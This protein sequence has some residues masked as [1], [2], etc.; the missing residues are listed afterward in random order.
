MLPRVITLLLVV[1]MNSALL[2]QQPV[3]QLAPQKILRLLGADGKTARD[4]S[5]VGA[6][7]FLDQN[8]DNY[9]SWQEY[10]VNGRYGT[11][12][13]RG[14]IFRVTDKDLNGFVTLEEYRKNRHVTDEAKELLGLADANKDGYLSRAEF[15]EHPRIKNEKTAGQVFDMLDLNKDG[16][17][18]AAE[19]LYTWQT[20]MKSLPAAPGGETAADSKRDRKASKQRRENGNP[21]LEVNRQ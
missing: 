18:Y 1:L 17:T 4:A 8:R 3:H 10:V 13:I 6:F 20:W 12:I 15:L 7:R 9:L 16:W 2:S 14:A 19:Y 11:A 21:K 5:Y